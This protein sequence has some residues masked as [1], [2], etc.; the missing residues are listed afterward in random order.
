MLFFVVVV[1]LAMRKKAKFK[2]KE[3]LFF[4]DLSAESLDK[5]AFDYILSE[6][7]YLSFLTL[8]EAKDLLLL[9]WN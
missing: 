5:E 2:K 1:V 4:I 3:Y 9:L 8:F 7:E 6:T